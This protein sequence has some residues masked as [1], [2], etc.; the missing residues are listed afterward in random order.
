MLLTFRDTRR[1]PATAL[2]VAAAAL[3]GT[4]A[5]ACM[6]A[7]VSGTLLRPLPYPHADKLVQFV[8]LNAQGQTYPL[9]YREVRSILPLAKGVERVAA[10]N[11]ASAILAT[12]GNPQQVWL[13]ASG[14]ELGGLLP[15]TPR[16]GRGLRAAD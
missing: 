12:G 15:D 3:L 14:P 9:S 4:A 11:I 7:L 1:G 6:L 5:L 8:R 2:A 13:I 16:L 10:Y